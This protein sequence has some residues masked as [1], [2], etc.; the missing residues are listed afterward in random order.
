MLS[1]NKI[2]IGLIFVVQAGLLSQDQSVRDP[3][4]ADFSVFVEQWN[5][6]FESLDNESDRVLAEFIKQQLQVV[7]GWKVERRQ[8]PQ[9]YIA[10]HNK[11]GKTL[12]TYHHKISKETLHGLYTLR[13]MAQPAQGVSLKKK[14]LIG[15]GSA[16]ICLASL[17]VALVWYCRHSKSSSRI[18][19][20]PGPLALSHLHAG[21]TPSASGRL[22]KSLADSHPHIGQGAL[23]GQQG[24]FSVV[25]DGAI[26]RLTLLVGSSDANDL[27]T[28]RY[29][30]PNKEYT[31][32]GYLISFL[33]RSSNRGLRRTLLG[34]L[35]SIAK[36][37]PL[38][39]TIPC[40]TG[41]PELP[42][43]NLIL[44]YDSDMS[45]DFLKNFL[46]D[47][48]EADSESFFSR[49]SQ[50]KTLS[51]L[52]KAELLRLL[53]IALQDPSLLEYGDGSKSDIILLRILNQY[54]D[55]GIDDSCSAVRYLVE[56]CGADLSQCNTEGT[57]PL[58]L[59]SSSGLLGVVQY[60][61]GCGQ[62]NNRHICARDS[63][64]E[65][66]LD[67][68]CK[69]GLD[70]DIPRWHVAE[71]LLERCPDLAQMKNIFGANCWNVTL[72]HLIGQQ[73]TLK[74]IFS[75]KMA[76]GIMDGG[77]RMLGMRGSWEIDKL[78]PQL[79]ALNNVLKRLRFIRTPNEREEKFI[80]DFRKYLRTFVVLPADDS[81]GGKIIEAFND[82]IDTLSGR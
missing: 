66:A 46:T 37:Q 21:G 44:M 4:V 82:I 64:Y 24:H 48:D 17:I 36:I 58:M 60:L 3:L 6:V 30:L 70:E 47:K 22:D 54:P 53:R 13:N 49:L 56:C 20:P 77:F 27:L 69:A 74:G 43:D 16:A 65:T 76:F 28:Y 33:R 26:A 14:I 67:K 11:F 31:A 7:Y 57:T 35:E 50:G 68:A 41:S 25:D 61:C 39:C 18:L 42:L 2:L 15:A 32:L 63:T 59:A 81:S 9:N 8:V 52:S 38:L 78:E 10:L 51:K 55:L 75:F 29:S 40:M 19:N 5:E 12:K 79:I 73:T 80:Q 23:L 62:I 34:L 45:C 1:K 71:Y 72:G